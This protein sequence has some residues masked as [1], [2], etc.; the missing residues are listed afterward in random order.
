[1]L[2]AGLVVALS[3][4]SVNSAMAA[5]VHLKGGKN[6]EPSF[7][8]NILT[9][10]A[11]GEL[12]GLGEATSS[13][14]S[15]RPA[16]RPRIASTRDRRAPASGSAAGRGDTDGEQ[17]IPESEIENGNTPFDVE[18]AAPETPVPGAPGCPNANWVENIIDVAFTSATITV[19]QPP[20]TLVLTVTCT[21]ATPTS[22][23]AVPGSN[24][25]C[26]SG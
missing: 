4:L 6:A 18:T 5:S 17:A 25:S 21:F 7:T 11:A 19:E 2:V 10:E 15:P 8:D 14:S 9:L 20:G 23:G 1:M 26:T 3:M 24:V 16:T 13:S 12:A 22:N